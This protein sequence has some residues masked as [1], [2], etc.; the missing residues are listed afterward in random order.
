MGKYYVVPFTNEQLRNFRRREFTLRVDQV[1]FESMIRLKE[2]PER[3]CQKDS[4]RLKAAGTYPGVENHRMRVIL[5]P[6]LR[7]GAG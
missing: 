1:I 3:S 6:L 5:L 4:K 7:Q 2:H